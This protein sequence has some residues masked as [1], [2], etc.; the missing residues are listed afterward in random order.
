MQKTKKIKLKI[1][2]ILIALN[3]L[4]IL[5]CIF[6]YGFRFFHY[7]KIENPKIAENEK[8]SDLVTIKNNIVTSGDGLYKTEDSYTFEGQNV[9]NYIKYSG[10][11]WRI[12][13]VDKDG[14][15]KMITEEN[16][17]ILVWGTTSTYE[18]SYVYKWLNK[19]DTEYNGI[20]YNTLNN[21]EK[22][23][24][25]IDWCS[26]ILKE[27]ESTCDITVNAQIGL[28][29]KEEYT[30]ANEAKS[31]LNNST[32]WWTSN[33]SETDNVWYIN[34]K[35]VLDNNSTS[36]VSYHS[37]G[38]R[39]VVALKN[40]V[41]AIG[42]TG[43]K[44]SPYIIESSSTGVLNKKS[45]GE[46]VTYNSLNW[47]IIERNDNYVKL[48]LDGVI[49]EDGKEYTQEYSKTSNIFSTTNGVGSY[50]NNN[51]Y[52]SL[53]SNTDIIDTIVGIN[54]YDSTTD[55]DYTKIYEDK[56]TAK[57]GLLQIGDL[58]ISEYEDYFLA[59]RT[60]TYEG[61]I[62][63]VTEN[64]KVYADLLSNEYKIRPVISLNPT[65]V[66]TSGSG[67]KEEPYIIGG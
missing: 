2:N 55:Y 7:Y 8:L 19:S 21:P 37:F 3:L 10:R 40:S 42:G 61:T 47:R 38:V 27:D 59:A 1:K 56:V 12:V 45:V 26:D 67:T 16:Q 25:K 33:G 22:F 46:Y 34:Q 30:L 5:I 51:F 36:G 64:S 29:S 39:P 43:T 49:K 24:T 23:L 66:I 60:S 31:Y 65:L 54:R 13:S 62:Y 57:V 48:A 20:F 32:Y 41:V 17:T 35:G 58:F 18:S 63:H 9:N 28:L 50:I 52:N 15:V 6:Y 11:L 53:K 44:D 4:F 14:I